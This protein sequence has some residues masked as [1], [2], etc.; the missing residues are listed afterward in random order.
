MPRL[1]GPDHICVDD[2]LDMERLV[3]SIQAGET[4]KRISRYLTSK[5]KK[6]IRELINN[7]I[8]GYPSIFYIADKNDASLLRLWV[9]HGA[10][11]NATAGR[12]RM[13]LLVFVIL[14]GGSFR[15]DT[16]EL[17]CTLLSL[18][19]LP[20]VIPK[21]F[22][23]PFERTL[24]REGPSEDMPKPQDR[25]GGRSWLTQPATRDGICRPVWAREDRTRTTAE[26]SHLH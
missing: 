15:C 16:T 20:N 12:P 1:E 4:C 5:D 24:P 8:A 11:V 18:G 17:V 22:Y 13:P 14:R 19:A 26:E 21:A 25:A 23:S 3:A 10:D 2:P 9:K 6:N 7:D